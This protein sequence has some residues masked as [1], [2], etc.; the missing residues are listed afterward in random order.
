MKNRL[1]RYVSPIL[2]GLTAW[3]SGVAMAADP[4]QWPPTGVSY[5]GDPGA[6]NISGLW[7]GTETGIPGEQFGPNRGPADG[8]PPTFFAPW[9]LPYTPAYQ[10]IYDERVAAAKKG[11]QL[12]DISAKCLPFGMPRALVSKIY[13]DEIV[14]T[15]GEVTLFIYSTFPVVIWTDGR[16]HPKDLKPSYNGHSIGYWMGDTLFVDTIGINQ[17]TPLDTARDP[18][19]P[20]LHVKWSIQRVADDILHFHVTLYDADAFTQPVTTTNLWQR[21]TDPKWQLLD[22]ASCFENN[23]SQQTPDTGFIKF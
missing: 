14:Q 21:K 20:D 12:G 7:L 3:A 16:P 15:P 5:Y 19:G 22:D 4:P 18:H 9:P 6:P 1:A 13:P 8:R 2:A 10:K 11:K 23:N 17:T